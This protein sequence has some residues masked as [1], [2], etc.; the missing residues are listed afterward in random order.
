MPYNTFDIKTTQQVFQLEIIEKASLFAHAQ[1]TS[2]SD[3]FQL[4]LEEN[5]P[6][7][8]SI[9]TEKA[10]SELL[11]SNV[12]I[13]LRKHFARNISFFPALNSMSTKTTA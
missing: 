9:N 1:E 2:I 11:V 8:V 7:A 3:Y 13:E 4:T 5:V 6:L 10:R 12:L